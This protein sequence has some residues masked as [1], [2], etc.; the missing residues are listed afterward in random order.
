MACGKPIVA[1]RVGGLPELVED[2]RTGWLFE[3]GNAKDLC[4]KLRTALAS[5]A[6]CTKFGDEAKRQALG[7]PLAEHADRLADIYQQLASA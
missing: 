7:N 2:G 5:P 1:S 6:L 4:A 3:R